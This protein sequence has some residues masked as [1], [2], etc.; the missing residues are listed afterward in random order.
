VKGSFGGGF[1]WEGKH[2]EHFAAKAK[3][4]LARRLLRLAERI[5]RAVRS[6]PREKLWVKLYACGKSVGHLVLRIAGS[7]SHPL[8]AIIAG[9]GYVR[10]R[11][12]EFTDTRGAPPEVVLQRFQEVVQL[13]V[14]ALREHTVEQLTEPVTDEG[15]VRT[16]FGLFMASAAHMNNHI[17]QTAYLIQV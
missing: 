5:E 14:K 7:L 1:R 8:G 13:V 9:T 4:D 16:R 11:C 17:G 10:D 2:V 12:A 6:L 3:E 15:P